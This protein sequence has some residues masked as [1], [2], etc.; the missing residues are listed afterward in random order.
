VESQPRE[1]HPKGEDD[2]SDW[3]CRQLQLRLTPAAIIDREIQVA[4]RR[5]GI[6]TRIDLT[7]TTPTATQ[8]PSTA[9][10]IAEAKLVTDPGLMTAMQDQLVQR[11]LIPAGLQHGIYLVYWIDPDQRPAGSAKG[12]TDRD[13]L[14]Q[15]LTQQAA[16]AGDGLQ[17]HPY[18]L[19]ISHP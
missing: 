12:P 19:D 5:Q 1:Q 11:Y 8:P 15:Q 17:I 7:A 3:V 18:I 9:R 13:R 6:G 16:E 10:V 4:R 14:K 2:I